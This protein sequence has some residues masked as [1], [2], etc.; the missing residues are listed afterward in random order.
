[1]LSNRLPYSPISSHFGS[2]ICSE[3]VHFSFNWKTKRSDLQVE[4][5]VSFIVKSLSHW[6]INNLWFYHSSKCHQQLFPKMLVLFHILHI[7]LKRKMRNANRSVVFIIIY[8]SLRIKHAAYTPGNDTVGMNDNLYKYV[9]V[10][11]KPVS[12]RRT[13]WVGSVEFI[14]PAT[15]MFL[16]IHIL[17][18]QNVQ[19]DE[20]STGHTNRCM[21]LK[22]RPTEWG[23]RRVHRS[24][25]SLTALCSSLVSSILNEFGV[26]N[27]A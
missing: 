11:F 26:K 22:Q 20:R 5:C 14:Q 7:G 24:K 23:Y 9:F 18:P 25:D 4:K 2:I 1:M 13:E 3:N 15:R 12:F 6:I 27:G 8:H 10:Y 16:G 17:Q 21:Q 19:M